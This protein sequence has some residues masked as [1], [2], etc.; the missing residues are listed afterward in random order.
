VT[1]LRLT[2]KPPPAQRLLQLTLLTGL[3]LLILAGGRLATLSSPDA[4]AQAAAFGAWSNPIPWPTVN[5]HAA[6]LPTGRVLQW[7]YPL[8][9]NGNRVIGHIWDPPPEL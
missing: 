8:D 5:I 7:A 9:S 1:N 4:Q 2:G 6:V 3:V